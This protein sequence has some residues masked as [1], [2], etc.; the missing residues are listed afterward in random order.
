MQSLNN[1]FEEIVSRLERLQSTVDLISTN[2]PRERPVRQ[3]NPH[4]LLNL[5]DVAAILKVPVNTARYYIEKKQLPAVKN[6]KA[7]KI[8]QSDFLEW[9]D[10]VFL[11]KEEETENS[12]ANPDIAP[13]HM[14]EIYHRFKKG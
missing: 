1:P 14:R 4:T 13:A 3:E 8:K 9:I 2:Q 6:G 5:R 10:N 12:G 11:K 7:F